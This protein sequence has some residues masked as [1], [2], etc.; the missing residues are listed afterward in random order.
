MGRD[1]CGRWMMTVSRE[2]L[3]RGRVF[4]CVLLLC[5]ISGWAAIHG[6]IGDR[7]NA[8]RRGT[9]NELPWVTFPQPGVLGP[10]PAEHMRGASVKD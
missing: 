10:A 6:S 5:F 7:Q 2:R 9:R 1:F 8:L 3:E 4:V